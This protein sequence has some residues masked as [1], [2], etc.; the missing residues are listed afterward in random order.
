M[1][2]WGFK[3]APTKIELFQI[4]ALILSMLAGDKTI[5][6]AKYLEIFAGE[7]AQQPW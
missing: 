3:I 1:V 4:Q 7:S 5:I 2:Q 6:Q